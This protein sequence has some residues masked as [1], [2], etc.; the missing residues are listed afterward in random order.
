M[1]ELLV[2]ATCLSSYLV[3]SL[4]VATIDLSFIL[5]FSVGIVKDL[6]FGLTPPFSVP[7]IGA[8]LSLL[9]KYLCSACNLCPV[10]YATQLSDLVC[11]QL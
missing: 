7:S 10:C 11:C 6:V 1:L 9:I 4:A 8:L 3:V 2:C 5:V